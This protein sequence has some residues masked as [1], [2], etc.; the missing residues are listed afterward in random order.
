MNRET[1]AN[2]GPRRGAQ[3]IEGRRGEH[4]ANA[5]QLG[6][7]L[8]HQGGNGVAVAVGDGKV[9]AIGHG[10]VPAHDLA[11]VRLGRHV[12]TDVALCGRSPVHDGE[13]GVPVH[14]QGKA[15]GTAAIPV[16]VELQSAGLWPKLVQL[17]GRAHAD[18]PLQR[19]QS[20][21]AEG[22]DVV[23]AYEQVRGGVRIGRG[24][25][26]RHAA[27]PLR[28]AVEAVT[29][30]RERLTI[31]VIEAQGAMA[32]E[33][34]RAT[35]ELRQ[36]H[37]E[38]GVTIHQRHAAR[39]LIRPLCPV[40]EHEAPAG[41]QV[42]QV[43]K[44]WRREVQLPRGRADGPVVGARGH[45]V[46]RVGPPVADCPNKEV[47][48]GARALREHAALVGECQLLAIF[49]VAGILHV[50]DEVRDG[51]QHVRPARANHLEPRV[52]AHP[53]RKRQLQRDAARH[54]VRGSARRRSPTLANALQVAG[55]AARR[56]HVTRGVV[57]PVG[58]AALVEVQHQRN[59]VLAGAR[60]LE[61]GRTGAVVVHDGILLLV[62]GD[63]GII[64][65]PMGIGAGVDLGGNDCEGTLVIA[66]AVVEPEP[67]VCHRA[68][69]AQHGRATDVLESTLRN[70]QHP[71]ALDGPL[72][73]PSG[74][75][76]ATRQLREP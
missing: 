43:R 6:H 62:Q 7:A 61:R 74:V 11:T 16:K 30:A 2:P 8:E 23:L 22:A 65:F 27:E 64:R 63:R 31:H 49:V 12:A 9:V 51:L 41:I 33:L 36:L 66:A 47:H 46:E 17:L 37:A 19:G 56:R 20:G 60:V 38:L 39:S 54:V 52:E 40:L 14:R 53:V 5:L 57:A 67:T 71:L 1:Y 15:T 4:P 10:E 45:A 13:L 35:A 73:G 59:G 26:V 72:D 70:H 34:V 58:L 32:H 3:A 28:A 69:A 76:L 42:Q 75:R 68:G 29:V 44:L 18:R 50:R 55:N 24:E 21:R 48:H 25:E